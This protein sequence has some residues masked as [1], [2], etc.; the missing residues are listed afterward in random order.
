MKQSKAS[1]PRVIFSTLLGLSLVGAALAF[2][3]MSF[4]GF[5][6]A[7]AQTVTSSTFAVAPP[8]TA[9]EHVANPHPPSS[10]AE[11]VVLHRELQ[12]TQQK[13]LSVLDL[14]AQQL[15][16]IERQSEELDDLRKRIKR[17]EQRRYKNR[18]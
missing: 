10:S 16:M 11:V 2:S 3:L 6:P 4:G 12:Q 8:P 15:S 17:L 5:Q 13:L 18:K 7:P 14:Q 1:S 9:V